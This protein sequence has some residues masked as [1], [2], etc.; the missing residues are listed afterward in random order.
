MASAC[1]F[2]GIVGI[3]NAVPYAL[4]ARKCFWKM[5][6][7]VPLSLDIEDDLADLAVSVF[8]FGGTT[9][10]PEDG[11]YF[12]NACVITSTIDE[13]VSLELY[14]VD[15]MQ[16]T[17]SG[18]TLPTIIV[19]SKVSRGSSELVESRAFD[20]D[21]MQYGI[22]PQQLAR[23]RCFYPEDHPRLTKT[24]VPTAEKHII[25]QGCISE[26]LHN[27]CIVRVHNITLGP[28]SGVVEKHRHADAVPPAKLKSFNWSGGGKGKGK[29]A[30]HTDS[31]V[32]LDLS[33]RHNDKA[34]KLDAL[35]DI[36]KGPSKKKVSSSK[37]VKKGLLGEEIKPVPSSK[38]A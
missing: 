8:I 21:I 35:E 18:R 13:H 30:S 14:C 12:I 34:R 25:V 19:I 37:L 4:E 1:S 26:L 22:M 17:D 28:S 38:V 36:G 9:A 27:R 15:E 29:G 32:D 11:I 20:M 6:G 5:D 2:H 33:P 3:Q 24:P 31:D 23:I 7:F 16:P 10:P